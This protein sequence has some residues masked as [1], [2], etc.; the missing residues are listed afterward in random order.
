[1]HAETHEFILRCWD[2]H[3]EQTGLGP[4]VLEFGSRD[5]NGQARTVVSGRYRN[6]VGIDMTA[7]NGVDIVADA[8]TVDL[9]GRFD[10]V[11]CTSVFEHTPVWPQIMA[12]AVRHMTA[13]GWLLISAP[14][15]GFSAHSAR[16]EGPPE[17]DAWYQNVTTDE[18]REVAEGLNLHV[19]ECY[20]GGAWGVESFLIARKS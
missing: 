17:A 3:V 16:Y 13:R 1:M 18:L 4:W 7:G 8:A 19:V 20:V 12:N 2:Q 5:V 14:G 11:V 6:W 10:V 15:P 9:D